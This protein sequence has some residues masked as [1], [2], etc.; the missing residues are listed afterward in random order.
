[1]RL[2]LFNL[3][4]YAAKRARLELP[5]TKRNNFLFSKPLKS[6]EMIPAQRQQGGKRDRGTRGGKSKYVKS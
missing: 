5:K 2:E 4:F 6:I 3:P 1:M